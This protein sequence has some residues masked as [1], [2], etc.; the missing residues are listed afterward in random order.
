MINWDGVLAILIG[1]I[2]FYLGYYFGKEA[3]NDKKE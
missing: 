3:R 2:I 1:A